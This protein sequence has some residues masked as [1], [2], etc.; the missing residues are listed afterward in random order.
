MT[1]ADR[2]GWTVVLPVKNAGRAKSR[3]AGLRDAG[4]GLA[5]AIA[6]DT[7]EAVAACP[8]VA[9]VVVVTDDDGLAASVPPGVVIVEDHVRS[10]P[11][12]AVEAAMASIPGSQP[13]AALLADLAALRPAELGQALA[14]ADVVDR[15]ANRSRRRGRI[16]S[17]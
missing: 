11:N 16:S 14:L 17:P 1:I 13:R 6:L 12:A 5:R 3:L 4:P 9:R 15:H 8:A 10:G 2:T 7:I